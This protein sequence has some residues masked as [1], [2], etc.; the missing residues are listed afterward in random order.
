MKERLGIEIFG[1]G[2]ALA[3]FAA[4]EV[5][6]NETGKRTKAYAEIEKYRDTAETTIIVFIS[7]DEIGHW[8]MEFV[9][10]RTPS[11]AALFFC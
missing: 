10:P 7:L 5:S 3:W 11:V 6:K 1:D 8:N 9:T 4:I 2:V